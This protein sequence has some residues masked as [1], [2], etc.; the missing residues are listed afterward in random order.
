MR[1]YSRRVLRKAFATTEKPRARLE[2][3]LAL[4]ETLYSTFATSALPTSHSYD[5]SKKRCRQGHCRQY[6]EIIG[7]KKN[8]RIA[9]P[10]AGISRV[11]GNIRVVLDEGEDQAF[12][13]VSYSLHHLDKAIA[14]AVAIDWGGTEVLTDSDGVK[15]GNGLGNIL[16]TFTEQ[17]NKTYKA[18]G[19]LHALRRLNLG[20]KRAKHIARKNL[21]RK[22]QRTR[23]KVLKA[24]IQTLA[25]QAVKEVIYGE[26]SRTRARAL[27]N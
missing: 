9:L 10:L 20:S 6:V 7:A 25:G 17:N 27:L 24:S 15:H 5:L 2:R 14:D 16:E 11:S 18:K 19:K 12:A 23:R 4:D 1:K 3:Q 21:G 13:R 22:E 8:S 26:G